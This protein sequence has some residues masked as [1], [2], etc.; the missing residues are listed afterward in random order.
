MQPH[1][2]EALSL[3]GKS[4]GQLQNPPARR[5]QRLAWKDIWR[6][7]G[8]NCTCVQALWQD[9]LCVGF[10]RQLWKVYVRDLPKVWP[11]YDCHFT[12]HGVLVSI[13]TMQWLGTTCDLSS[14]KP[15]RSLPSVSLILHLSY[16]HDRCTV[17]Q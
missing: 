4:P 2:I 9:L 13:M 14:L 15:R 11:F 12:H 8:S 7:A 6:A 3:E 17:A 1:D 16:A 10:G 5:A